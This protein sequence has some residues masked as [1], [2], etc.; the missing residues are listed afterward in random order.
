MF[1]YQD[2]LPKDFHPNSRVWIYQSSRIF[3]MTEA[4]ELEDLFADFVQNWKS[5]GAAVKGYA[6]LFFGRFIVLMADETEATVS[7]CSTDSSVKLIK[8]IEQ[9]YK[10]DMFNRQNLAFVIKDKIE[11]LPLAQLNYALQNGFITSE[12]LYFNNLVN[13][14]KDLET[15]W[16]CPLKES[17]LAQKMELV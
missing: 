15:K 14:K 3:S 9:T 4:F 10:V 16:L 17:W 8:T 11:V 7:G 1:N 13:T 6:N 5:H 2:N 12:T